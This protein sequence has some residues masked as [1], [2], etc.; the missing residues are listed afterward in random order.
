M[1]KPRE[2][3]V[4]R[5]EDVEKITGNN[6]KYSTIIIHRLKARNLIKQVTKNRYTTKDNIYLIASNLIYPS[7]IS[8]WSA[9]AFLGYTEQM[10]MT[11]QV[12]VTKRV[13]SI[14]FEGYKI[15]AQFLSQ[16]T[17]N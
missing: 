5:I 13:K 7:Y 15:I 2:R 9:S 16:K 14:N 6:R 4:F 8:F 10:P 1:D 11:I 3:P 17:K 12:A